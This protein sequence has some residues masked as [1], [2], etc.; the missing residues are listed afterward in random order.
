MT[1][2]NAATQNPLSENGLGELTQ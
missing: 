1:A 2:V